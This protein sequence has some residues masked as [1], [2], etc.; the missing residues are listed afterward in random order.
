MRTGMREPTL[1]FPDSRAV[2]D[3]LPEGE[4]TRFKHTYFEINVDLSGA[5]EPVGFEVPDEKLFQHI[6]WSGTLDWL[7]DPEEDIYSLEDGEPV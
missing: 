6:V 7:A 2:D 3:S 4:G 1:Q 5:S